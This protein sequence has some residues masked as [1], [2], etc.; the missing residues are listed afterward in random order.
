MTP[1]HELLARARWD[2]VFGAARF[3]IGYADH[4]ARALLKLPLERI[5]LAEG[6]H[7]AF[8]FEDEDGRSQR[9]P[10]H[11]VREVW[12]DGVLIWRRP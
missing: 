7:F 4:R 11:R 10:L 1:I 6:S 3:V 5:R 9:V 2:P 8:E 12:R